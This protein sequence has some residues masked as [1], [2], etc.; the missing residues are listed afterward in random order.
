MTL[1]ASLYKNLMPIGGSWVSVKTGLKNFKYLNKNVETVCGKQ[2]KPSVLKVTV[3]PENSILKKKGISEITMEK[4]PLGK[5][6]M[7][8]DNVGDIVSKGIVG[9]TKEPFSALKKDVMSILQGKI[10]L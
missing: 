9:S 6:V 8:I 2:Q 3:L 7:L 4:S 10:K 5:I 1:T